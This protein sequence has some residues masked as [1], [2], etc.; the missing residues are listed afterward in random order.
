MIDAVVFAS[1]ISTRYRSTPVSL[2]GR[3]VQGRRPTATRS[4]AAG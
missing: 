3:A 2:P 4:R 1:L